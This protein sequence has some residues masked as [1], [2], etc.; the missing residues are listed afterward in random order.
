MPAK[1]RHHWCWDAGGVAATAVAVDFAVAI[2]VPAVAVD[3]VH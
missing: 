2:A 1:K 3:V